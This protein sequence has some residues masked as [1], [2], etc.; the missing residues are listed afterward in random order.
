MSETSIV[1]ILASVGIVLAGTA[2]ADAAVLASAVQSGLPDELVAFVAE[3]P[4][5][6]LA[7]EALL[8][9]SQIS[10]GRPED[11]AT[12]RVNPD[13]YCKL[14]ITRTTE[15]KALVSWESTGASALGL[16][17]LGIAAG[18]EMPASGQQEIE[19][20][21]FAQVTMTAMDA[22]G[23]RIRCWVALSGNDGDFE[24]LASQGDDGV[25]IISA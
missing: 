8:L 22:A 15:G 1:A 16:V 7:P 24:T 3:H 25:L 14:R 12:S 23:N 20:G 21:D 6:R 11:A 17:P 18:T 2:G 13:L 5:S 9:A 4:E 10:L 19:G